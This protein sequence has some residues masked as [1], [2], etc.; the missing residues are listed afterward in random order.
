M[1]S[2]A[3]HTLA[4]E[5]ARISNPT[6]FY[7]LQYAFVHRF[8]LSAQQETPDPLR[9]N[10]WEMRSNT[11]QQ[12]AEIE[13]DAAFVKDAASRILRDSA[14]YSEALIVRITLPDS[15]VSIGKFSVVNYDV[16]AEEGEVV[17]A[18][19]TLRSSEALVSS[20]AS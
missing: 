13:A 10:P 18:A 20:L 1:Q 19:F 5:F 12:S 11:T 7:P 4:L 3:A 15:S 16:L 8:S 6:V 14:F 9:D 2:H 17:R